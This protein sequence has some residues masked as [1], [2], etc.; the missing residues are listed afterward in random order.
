MKPSLKL[1]T[2]I[3]RAEE[4]SL[5]HIHAPTEDNALIKDI[6]FF[7]SSPFENDCPSS[8]FSHL[9]LTWKVLLRISITHS[10]F[11][12]KAASVKQAKLCCTFNL[13][14]EQKHL[15]KYRKVPVK[16]PI[17]Y[18]FPPLLKAA[19]VFTRHVL[20]ARGG[21]TVNVHP[22]SSLCLNN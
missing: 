15:V 18:P 8:F 19:N 7:V 12:L 2:R 11:P 4:S 10:I 17:L 21:K 5:G 20:H 22:H 1:F 16:T 13:H 14:M 9:V 6:I 3:N